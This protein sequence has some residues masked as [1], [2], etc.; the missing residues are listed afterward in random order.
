LHGKRELYDAERR[1]RNPDYEIEC[2][3]LKEQGL[4]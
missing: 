4:V 3:R 2:G 1:R